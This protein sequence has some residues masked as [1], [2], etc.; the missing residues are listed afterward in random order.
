MNDPLQTWRRFDYVLLVAV[1]ALV[2]FGIMMIDSATQDAIDDDIISRVP[3]QISFAIAGTVLLFVMA[4]IDYRL[5][6][7][8]SQW[9]YLGM[10]LL[11]VIVLVFGVEGAGGAR[12]WLNIGIRIQPSEI[13]KL[14]IIISL[15]QFVADRYLNMNRLRT[16]FATM[17]HLAI[18]AALILSQPDLGTTIVYGVIWAL[19][20]WSAGLRLRHLALLISVGLLLLVLVYPV[21]RTYQ[22]ERI[23][24]FLQPDPGSDAYYNIRQALIGIGSGGVFGKGYYVGSQNT[25]RFLRVRHTDF[26]FSVIAHEF[27]MVG[28]VAVLGV[29]ALVLARILRGAREASD[30]LG[31]MICYGV[32]AVIFFQTTVSI[33]M[34]LNLLPVTGLTLPFVSS[35]GTS[36]LFTMAGIGLVQS[37]IVR[38]RIRSS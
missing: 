5:L 20:V 27:G 15:S 29:F 12:R 4:A 2:V 9:L 24:T 23:E 6:G 25:G 10:V 31:S 36:L 1:L 7:G 13:G 37:V 16:V 34:N 38:R 18:P 11:L 35:G 14:L 8:V 32:A 28:G 3:D 33:G 30:P 22:R 19:I 21:L 17:L 26:I